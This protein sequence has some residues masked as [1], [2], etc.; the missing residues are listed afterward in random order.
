M[1]VVEK[2]R[3]WKE[4]EDQEKRG[5]GGVGGVEEACSRG[6]KQWEWRGVGIGPKISGELMIPIL[7]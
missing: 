7:D 2:V 4:W 1:G 6:E 5:L 3:K